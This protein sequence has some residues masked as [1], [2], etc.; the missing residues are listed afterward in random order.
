MQNEDQSGDTI[1][2]NSFQNWQT[3]SNERALSAIANHTI[4]TGS[5]VTEEQASYGHLIPNNDL[6]G[7]TV[8]IILS[9]CQQ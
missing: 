1:V 6:V 4:A 7:S 8:S 3:R 5:L 9:A 2:S